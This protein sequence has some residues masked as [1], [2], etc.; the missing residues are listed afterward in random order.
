MTY[1]IKVMLSGLSGA[2]KTT[3]LKLLV[4]NAHLLGEQQRMPTL[5]EKQAW[6]LATGEMVPTSM[7][8]NFGVLV[9]T[10]SQDWGE[11]TIN[12]IDYSPKS[13]DIIVNIFDTCG[14]DIFYPLRKVSSQSTQG[15]LFFIDSALLQLQ[16]DFR[17]IQKI[18]NAFEELRTFLGKEFEKIPIIFICNKQDLIKTE[19]GKAGFI[20]KTI[21]FYD[22]AFEKYTFVNASAI[23]GWGPEEALLVLL[24]KIA[25]RFKWDQKQG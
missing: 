7:Y 25:K 4:K 12:P 5:A 14:Q 8:T 23:Q 3:S 24:D 19:K 11:Y 17:N 10:P 9:V 6:N 13:R 18:I 2:G 16:L 20:K 21:A 15:I 22:S 1:S